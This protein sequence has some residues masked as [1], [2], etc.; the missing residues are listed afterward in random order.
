MKYENL[1]TEHKNAIITTIIELKQ[2]S[3]S[4]KAWAGQM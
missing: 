3:K 4:A 1:K 2:A